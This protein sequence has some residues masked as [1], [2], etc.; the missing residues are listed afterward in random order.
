M[1]HRTQ[2]IAH[3]LAAP[4]SRSR[5]FG[6]AQHRARCC[7]GRTS[8]NPMPSI[9]RSR[10]RGPS[11][12]I[13]VLLSLPLIYIAWYTLRK[14][15]SQSS[16]VERF[17]WTPKDCPPSSPTPQTDGLAPFLSPRQL[18]CRPPASKSSHGIPKYFHQSWVSTEL[19]AKFRKWSHTCRQKHPDW[20]WV[21]WTDDDNLSLIQEFFP[22]LEDTYM[23][24][25]A[26]IYR[27]DLVRNLYMYMFGG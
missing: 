21:L 18:F 27:V 8:A 4:T 7:L 5:T 23:S 16:L 10:R 2:G 19:P 24:L 17:S 9:Q 1:R 13:L 26:T 14:T 15:G 22:W 11:L 6:F 20:E 12:G 25:P 3:A